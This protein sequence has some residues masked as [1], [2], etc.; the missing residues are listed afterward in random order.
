MKIEDQAKQTQESTT[1]KSIPVMSVKG[2][3]GTTFR[4]LMDNLKRRQ[5]QN[6]RE[7]RIGK[8]KKN[9]K[10]NGKSF[11]LCELYKYSNQFGG[12]RKKTHL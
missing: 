6:Q 5:G 2:L 1:L 8:N 12:H 7:L 10:T 11:Y 9:V 3:A 4:D